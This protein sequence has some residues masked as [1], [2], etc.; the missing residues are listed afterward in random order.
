MACFVVPGGEAV[1]ATV[2]QKIIE[3]REKKSGRVNSGP[4]TL[5]WSR[6]LGWLNKMLWG[7]TILLAFEHLWHGE[8][9]FAPPFLTAMKS[10]E[11]IPVML[12]E[13]ATFGSAMAV[14]ITVI[15][16]IMVLIAEV[17]ARRINATEPAGAKPAEEGIV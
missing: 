15:W 14:A 12:R 13:M 4:F 17:K 16:G 3:K 7:G 11:E 1:V 8:I 9:S 5:T 10:A 2:I 6:R